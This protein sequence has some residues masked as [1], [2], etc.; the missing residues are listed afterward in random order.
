MTPPL[1]LDDHEDRATDLA[2]TGGKGSSLAVLASVAGIEVPDFFCVTTAAFEETLRDCG[3]APAIDQ[4]QT[5]SDAWLGCVDRTRRRA[6]QRTLFQQAAALRS[7]IEGATMNP[8]T[9]Q[10]IASAYGR[11]EHRSGIADLAVAVRSSATTEDLEEEASFWRS[12]SKAS[13]DA[14]KIGISPEPTTSVEFA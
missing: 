13:S 6:L 11:L 10:A 7:R 14:V 5:A 8:A 9:R 4:L 1:V 3:L 12:R 2:L